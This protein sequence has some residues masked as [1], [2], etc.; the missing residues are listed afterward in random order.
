MKRPKEDG[1]AASSFKV[2]RIFLPDRP[3]MLAALRVVLGM[4]RVIPGMDAQ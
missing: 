4:P 1:R 3:S 2:E